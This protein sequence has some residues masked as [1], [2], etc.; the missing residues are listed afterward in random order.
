M[1]PNSETYATDTY[2]TLFEN[3]GTGTF[4]K[5]ADMTLSMVNSGFERLT[6]YSK[7]EIE[8]RMK[9]SDI[10][11]PEDRERVTRY[12]SDRRSHRHAPTGLECRI[13]NRGGQRRDVWLK[14]DMVPGTS[15]SVGSFMDITRLKEVERE[16]EEGRALLNAIVESFDGLLYVSDQD[17]RLRYVNERLA[18]QIGRC[19][20]GESCFQALHGRRSV[21]PFCVF[22]QVQRGERVCFQTKN[23]ID[24]RWYSSVNSPIRHPGGSISLLALV[25]DIHER[26]L[27]EAALREN[28]ASLRQQNTVLQST[29]QMRHKFGNLVGKSPAMQEVYRQIIQ[30]AATDA[31]VIIYGEP[32]TGKE[33]VAHAIHDVGARREGPFVPVHCGAIPE[34]LVESEFFG[35]VRGAFSGAEA[36]KPGYLAYANNGTIFLDEIGEISPTMQ[37]KLL[38]VIEGGGF[39]PVGSNQVRNAH[40]RFI[41]ATNRDLKERVNNRLMREDFFYRIHILPIRLPSLRERREDLPLL[42]HHFLRLYSGKQNLPPLTER[43]IDQL[44]QYDWPGNVRELQNVIIRFCSLKQLDLTPGP[45]RL[46]ETPHADTSPAAAIPQGRTLKERLAAYERELIAQSLTK[47]QWRRGRVATLLGI[48]RKTLFTKMKQHGLDRK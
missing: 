46:P 1:A 26:K 9:L 30:A 47:H 31:T 34:N 48:D 45:S 39:T 14:L 36:D 16:V 32:G 38:R 7:T 11:A 24:G 15:K 17:Y 10:V 40:V 8:G 13:L 20:I 42:I 5:D 27:A 6:G 43:M 28:A 4:I 23:P 37:V 33:L 29:V 12:H 22:D 41:A 19:A 44:C 2:R 18:D 3:T 21:C 25:T 35:Y